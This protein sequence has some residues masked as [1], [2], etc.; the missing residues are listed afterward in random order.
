MRRVVRAARAD[1]TILSRMSSWR[2]KDGK[3]RAPAWQSQDGQQC[4]LGHGVAARDTDGAEGGAV[5]ALR[6]ETERA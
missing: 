3:A 6:L 5:V 4:V 1:T 2:N